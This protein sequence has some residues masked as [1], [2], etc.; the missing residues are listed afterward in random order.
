MCCTCNVRDT[1]GGFAF[2]VR[3]MYAGCVRNV[4]V[5]LVH[6]YINCAFVVHAVVR[7]LPVICVSML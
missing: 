2:T 4:R 3:M 7:Y 6:V 5:I 1:C